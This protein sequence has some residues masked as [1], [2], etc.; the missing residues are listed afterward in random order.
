M[1]KLLV[2][3]LSA[4]LLAACG[5]TEVTEKEVGK[6]DSS[7]KTESVEEAPQKEQD[8]IKVDK[9][10]ANTDAVKITLVD[11]TKTVDKEFDEEYI[12][13]KYEVENKLDKTI[14]VQAAEVS[15]DGKMVDESMLDMSQEVSAGKVADAVLTIQ[16][17]EG[18]LPTLEKNLEMILN[19][20]DNETY[21]DI[22][23]HNVSVDFK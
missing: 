1:K 11:V 9:E 22:E 17:Y 15:A 3:G 2:V 16:N 13:V 7:E 5:D 12:E 21:E 14:A 8:V 19:V 23:K 20:F 4:F 6:V 10:I 18:D